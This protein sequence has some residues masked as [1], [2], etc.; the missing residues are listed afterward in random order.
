M[1]SRSRHFTDYQ[2]EE[3][4]TRFDE[5]FPEKVEVSKVKNYVQNIE[6]KNVARTPKKAVDYYDFDD[7]ISSTRIDI[8]EGA[9][10][11]DRTFNQPTQAARSEQRNQSIPRIQVDNGGAVS[12]NLTEKV[13]E[14][15]ESSMRQ[16]KDISLLQK[17]L[18]FC[19]N[20]VNAEVKMRHGADEMMN[21]KSR[22]LRE[23]E[24]TIEEKDAKIREL[25]QVLTQ[26]RMEELLKRHKQLQTRHLAPEEV[27]RKIEALNEKFEAT[28]GQ[29][30]S[31]TDVEDE[32][33]AIQE[34]FGV[35]VTQ[36]SELHSQGITV[37]EM[38]KA[39]SKLNVRNSPFFSFL[40]SVPIRLRFSRNQKPFCEITWQA[41]TGKTT[42]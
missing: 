26:I 42:D 3:G 18:D 16:I 30:K 8:V 36:L 35:L 12:M 38:L 22:Q 32:I 5:L 13:N 31:A 11:F 37:T 27:T 17:K 29:F 40:S 10:E 24:E 34:M 25:K 33:L 20:E 9:K 7:L 4:A 28:N 6:R 41:T 15:K 19:R 2:I 1:M 23:M 21:I 14:L 39:L